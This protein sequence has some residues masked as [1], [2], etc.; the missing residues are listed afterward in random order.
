MVTGCYRPVIVMHG[1]LDDAESLD[2]LV[3]FIKTAHPGTT[4]HNI[5]AFNEMVKFCK[6]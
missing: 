4:V 3:S 5:N 6:P 2:Q 1:I